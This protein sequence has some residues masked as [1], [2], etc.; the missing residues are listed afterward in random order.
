[1]MQK[2]RHFLLGR[3]FV[4]LKVKNY[5]VD[6][7]WILKLGVTI[8]IRSLLAYWIQHGHEL[9]AVIFG[10]GLWLVTL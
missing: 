6:V 3:K 2:F 8:N 5:V 1:M 9:G 10:A 7:V 4:K